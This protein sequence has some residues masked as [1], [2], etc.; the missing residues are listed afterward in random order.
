MCLQVIFGSGFPLAKQKSEMSPP[1]FTVMS[2]EMS[3]ILGG[4]AMKQRNTH[5][6][7]GFVKLWN[8]ILDGLAIVLV[9]C[10]N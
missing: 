9:C 5:K 4:T 3:Y 7:G 2:E 8:K 6:F 1:S 10:M